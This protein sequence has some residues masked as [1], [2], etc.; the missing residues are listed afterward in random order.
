MPT[1]LRDIRSLLEMEWIS[2]RSRLSRGCLGSE[3]ERL[4]RPSDRVRF[5]ECSAKPRFKEERAMES[6]G[7]PAREN[8]MDSKPIEKASSKRLGWE[9]SGMTT[10]SDSVEEPVVVAAVDAVDAV[11]T[12][13]FL[14]IPCS[15]SSKMTLQ[16]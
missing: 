3:S 10:G 9:S 5:S 4:P 8:S 15:I 14:G 2:L 11:G 13:G 6:K 1:Y 16:R 12:G 7:E